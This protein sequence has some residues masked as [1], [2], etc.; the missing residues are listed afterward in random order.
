MFSQ[1]PLWNSKCGQS[2]KT[3]ENCRLFAVHSDVGS[4]HVT[5]KVL[6]TL[7]RETEKKKLRHSNVTAAP[8]QS[9]QEKWRTILSMVKRAIPCLHFIFWKPLAFLVTNTYRFGQSTSKQFKRISGEWVL[10]FIKFIYNI[11]RNR[12]DTQIWWQSSLWVSFL[13]YCLPR[14]YARKKLRYMQLDR[15]IVFLT[16]AI[17]I[18]VLS[19]SG[20][21]LT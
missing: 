15:K 7:W 21:F 2:N 5:S 13:C 8:H 3:K 20:V 17:G 16:I 1:H 10:W 4:F 11:L 6:W 12:D 14:M 9:A 18:S 19:S